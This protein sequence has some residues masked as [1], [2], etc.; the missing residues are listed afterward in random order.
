MSPP[1]RPLLGVLKQA[2]DRHASVRAGVGA[3]R[4][5]MP[6]SGIASIIAIQS[7]IG[8]QSSADRRMRGSHASTPHPVGRQGQT[9][10]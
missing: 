8:G 5:Y 9:G 4:L 3:A 6:S 2:V 7:V 10:D 1:R